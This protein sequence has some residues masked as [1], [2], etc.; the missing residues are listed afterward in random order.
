MKSIKLFEIE[1]DRF[2]AHDDLGSARLYI[3]TSDWEVKSVSRF[4]F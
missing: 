3:V 4:F 1:L 2:L